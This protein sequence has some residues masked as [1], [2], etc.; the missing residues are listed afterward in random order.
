M[1]AAGSRVRACLQLATATV[2]TAEQISAYAAGGGNR[3]A[4]RT[5]A[6]AVV[7]AL[8]RDAGGTPLATLQNPRWLTNLTAALY[9]GARG[10]AA[11]DADEVSAVAAA[12]ARVNAAAA[13]PQGSDSLAA[14]T[15]LAKIGHVADVPFAGN[16][17]ALSDGDISL[18]QYRCARLRSSIGFAAFAA[19]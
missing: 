9:A 1:T 8:V 15:Q 16:A 19:H 14:L 17:S 13:A 4:A 3:T 11:A 5:A 6:D 2:S 18:Q 10:G 7:L 12:A